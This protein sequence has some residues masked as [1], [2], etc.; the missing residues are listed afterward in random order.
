MR[1]F[2]LDLVAFLVIALEVVLRFSMVVSVDNALPVTVGSTTSFVRV[3][4]VLASRDGRAI[5]LGAEAWYSNFGAGIEL[6]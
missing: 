6:T 3:L 4:V 2:R 5:G 1:C